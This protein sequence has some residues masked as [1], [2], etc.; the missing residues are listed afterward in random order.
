MREEEGGE[1][2]EQE[3]EK[4]NKKNKKNKKKRAKEQVKA[5]FS[6]LGG[7]R[8]L[9]NHR[10]DVRWNDAC[11]FKTLLRGEKRE[12]GEK[13]HELDESWKEGWYREKIKEDTSRRRKIKLI[14]NVVLDMRHF[15]GIL[16]SA[17][18]K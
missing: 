14:P 8:S 4:K 17:N 13:I 18:R 5:S 10:T 9:V 7:L 1:E 3:E 11:D 15:E 6:L 12:K 2:E 16:S